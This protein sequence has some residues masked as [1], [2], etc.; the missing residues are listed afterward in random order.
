[1]EEKA[2][3]KNIDKRYL[4]QGATE[5]LTGVAKT[6]YRSIELETNSWEE[7]KLA[8]RKEFLPLDYEESLW[9][10]IRGRKQGPKENVGIFVSNMLGLFS[11][12][13][14]VVPEEK[15]LKIIKNNLSPF[16]LEKL[17]LH[18]VMSIKQL[19]ELGKELDLSKARL[20]QYN[21]PKPKGKAL[22]PEFGCKGTRPTVN[23]VHEVQEDKGVK[24]GEQAPNKSQTR[25]VGCWQCGDFGHGYRFCSK[26]KKWDFCS[27]CGYKGTTSKECA[28]CR[29]RAVKDGDKGRNQGKVQGNSA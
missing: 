4:L 10:E 21:S 12:L 22:E 28:R 2:R 18:Q 7:L 26:P 24:V 16:Y 8:L 17:A 15:R 9:E 11:R 29:A 1:M 19:R 13:E 23:E 27:K 3:A 20:E 6:W 14:E 5:F 25:R